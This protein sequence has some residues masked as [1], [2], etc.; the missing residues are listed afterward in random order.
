MKKK[1][2]ILLLVLSLLTACSRKNYEETSKESNENDVSLTIDNKSKEKETDK[3]K[4]PEETG[5]LS[6][7]KIGD[8]YIYEGYNFDFGKD[9]PKKNYIKMIRKAEEDTSQVEIKFPE[10]EKN[11]K[12]IDLKFTY[13][14]K[15]KEITDLVSNKEDIDMK[16]IFKKLSM[17]HNMINF[18]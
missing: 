12:E 6:E 10:D 13:D 5:I 14:P 7:E 1:T 3:E 16:S 17:I 18:N 9:L 15:T 11:S 2:I 8:S 4:W